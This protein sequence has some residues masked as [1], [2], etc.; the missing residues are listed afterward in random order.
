MTAFQHRPFQIARDTT[1]SSNLL[2]EELGPAPTS[3]N[4][5]PIGMEDLSHNGQLIPTS[6]PL[7]SSTGGSFNIINPYH[8]VPVQAG[9]AWRTAEK[10]YHPDEARLLYKPSKPARNCRFL[11]TGDFFA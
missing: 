5:M 3:G 10:L 7:I 1:R 9:G 11:H 4:E 6:L 8:D 2:G